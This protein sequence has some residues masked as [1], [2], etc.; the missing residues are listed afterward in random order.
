MPCPHLTMARIRRWIGV[1]LKFLGGYVGGYMLEIILGLVGGLVFWLPG[2]VGERLAGHY[3]AYGAE[4][5]LVVGVVGYLL[6]AAAG[7]YVWSRSRP[8]A[9][10]L[11]AYVVTEIGIRTLTSP[12]MAT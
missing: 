9:L 7:W 11:W 10:G 5:R 2:G 6:V 3:L 1:V 12:S 8:V 4:A